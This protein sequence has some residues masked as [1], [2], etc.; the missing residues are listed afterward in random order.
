MA[1]P[2]YVK[3]ALTNLQAVTGRT[4]LVFPV[5]TYIANLEEIRSKL[6]AEKGDLEHELAACYEVATRKAAKNPLYRLARWFQTLRGG[7]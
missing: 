6:I 5:R 1:T 3:D 7:Q 4:D 2:D